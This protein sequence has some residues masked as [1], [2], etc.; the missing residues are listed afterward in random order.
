M[1]RDDFESITSFD[2]VKH[3]KVRIELTYLGFPISAWHGTQQATQCI[4]YLEADAAKYC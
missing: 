3:G 2:P 4:S 1:T